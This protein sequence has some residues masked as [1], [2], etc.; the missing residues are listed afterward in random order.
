MFSDEEIQVLVPG[1]RWVAAQGDAGPALAA[2]SAMSKIATASQ[3]E[4][5]DKIAEIG[6]W[7]PRRRR[8]GPISP[9]LGLIREAIRLEHKLQLR[10]VDASAVG[11]E[12]VVWP[13]ALGFFETRWSWRHGANCAATSGISG[14][15]A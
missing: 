6:L 10:Y 2:E 12:R 7:A 9:R 4:L 11:S 15:T 1:S 3:K 5:R 8:A 13:I 14:S